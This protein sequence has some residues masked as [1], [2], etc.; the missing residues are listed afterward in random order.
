MTMYISFSP[1]RSDRQISLERQGDMLLIDGEAFDF[2]PLPEGGTLPC[3]AVRS[4]VIVSDVQRQDG[5]LHLSVI[6]PHR[7]DAPRE[8]LFP[9]GIIVAED[10]LITLPN[11][12]AKDARA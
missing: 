9:K 4:D 10:G 6:L 1:V 7:A 8:V 12:T 2:S 5:N 3:E 11:T